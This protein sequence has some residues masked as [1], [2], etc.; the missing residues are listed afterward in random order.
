[1]GVDNASTNRT[2]LASF[3]LAWHPAA[4]V[5]REPVPGLTPARLCGIRAAQGDVLVFVDDDNVLAPD[6]L[7][8]VATVFAR[9]AKLGAAGGIVQPE[10]ETL[11]P[12]WLEEFRGLLALR[13][14]G[15]ETKL[16]TGGPGAIWPDFAPVGAGMC[17]RGAAAETY[18]QALAADDARRSLDRAGDSLASGGDCDLVFTAL[19]AG[20]TVGY[21]PE[22]VLTHLIPAGRMDPAYL[23]RLNQGIMRSWVCVLRLHGQ[24]PWP[25]IPRWTLPLRVARAWLRHGRER[26]PAARIRWRGIVGQL[27]GQADLARLAS[28]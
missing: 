2:A 23:G 22:L 12:P 7:A 24:C 14:F 8:H 3:D 27:E 10:W 21:F 6:Y 25:P 13:D 4:R 1:M 5:L 28:P 17:V 19:H 16:R 18:V 20:W 11:P 26:A 9:D 15:R